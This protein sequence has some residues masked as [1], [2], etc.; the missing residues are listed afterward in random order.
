[1]WSLYKI[2]IV[3]SRMS[4]LSR[5]SSSAGR[6]QKNGWD[7]WFDFELAQTKGPAMAMDEAEN[8]DWNALG[9]FLWVHLEN[10]KYL[11]FLHDKLHRVVG[12]QLGLGHRLQAVRLHPFRVCMFVE[13]WSAGPDR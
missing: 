2:L 8:I 3:M 5:S 12:P 11:V 9:E 1:M 4:M 7:D 10:V 13:L 6:W